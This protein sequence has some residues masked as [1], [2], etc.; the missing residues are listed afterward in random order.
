M[1]D[2]YSLHSGIDNNSDT[3][4]H[5]YVCNTISINHKSANIAAGGEAYEI[6]CYEDTSSSFPF[7][8]RNAGDFHLALQPGV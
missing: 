7:V 4:F 5:G 6:N 2:Y 3:G 1:G 8:D